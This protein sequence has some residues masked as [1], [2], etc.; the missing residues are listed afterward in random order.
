MKESCI[1]N[2]Y[3]LT[4]TFNNNVNMIIFPL[5]LRTEV[6]RVLHSAYQGVTA[7]NKRPKAIVYWPGIANH[8][9]IVPGIG[10]TGA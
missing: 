1:M 7:M 5:S 9:E 8:I 2:H 10:I 3:Q 6:L 4:A